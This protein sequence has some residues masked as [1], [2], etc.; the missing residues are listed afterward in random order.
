MAPLLMHSPDLSADVRGAL[1]AAFAAEPD[2]RTDYLMNA[3]RLMSQELALECDD[4]RELVGL[5]AG[6][7]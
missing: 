7:C 6:S 5:P 1:R 3:A 4:I 2:Q